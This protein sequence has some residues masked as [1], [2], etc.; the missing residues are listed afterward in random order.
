MAHR[1]EAP[2]PTL[3]TKVNETKNKVEPS[4]VSTT[5]ELDKEAILAAATEA[6]ELLESVNILKLLQKLML[7]L[8]YPAVLGA[9]LY[10]LLNFSKDLLIGKQAFEGPT[11]IKLILFLISIAFYICDYIYIIC[12]KVYSW[13]FFLADVLFLLLLYATIKLL[14]LE[15]ETEK[16]LP[17]NKLILL[18]YL[19]FLIA[20]F[21][22]DKSERNKSVPMSKSEKY[23]SSV[24]TW[25]KGSSIAILI[26]LILALIWGYFT[27]NHLVISIGTILLSQAASAKLCTFSAR[28]SVATHFWKC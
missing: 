27:G 25:E 18:C 9:L 17:H 1:P 5:E 10:E 11:I 14:N 23:F 16:F 28:L 12:T 22:W 3:R 6:D 15:P 20:Y 7:E 4:S 24:V 2:K 13:L 26:F 19:F 8:F 21:R